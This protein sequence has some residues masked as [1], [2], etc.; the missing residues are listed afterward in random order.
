MKI[1]FSNS[2]KPTA[3]SY[4][5]EDLLNTPINKIKISNN[6]FT[7]KRRSNKSDHLFDE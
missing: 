3:L 5:Y 6:I 1:F 4:P 2:I 7:D